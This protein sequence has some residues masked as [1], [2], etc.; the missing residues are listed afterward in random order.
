M[1]IDRQHLNRQH[2]K[3]WQEEPFD[4]RFKS[5]E[6]QH[7]SNCGNEF[8][9]NYCPHCS[10][11]AGVGRIGWKS[12]HQ[13]I[14]DIWGLG[15]RSLLYTLLQLLL[16][17]GQL[18]NDYISGKRQVSFPPV[19]MLFI[20]AVIYSGIAY[21]F[22]PDVLGIQLMEVEYSQLED[23]MERHYS[24]YSLLMSV[25]AILP[26]WIMFRN[27]PRNTRHTLPEGF[28]IQV[29]LSVLAIA[30]GLIFLPLALI[31]PMAL[32]LLL[33]LIEMIYYIIAYKELFGYSLWGT[34]W[35]QA[36]VYLAVIVFA[37]M[38]MLVSSPDLA[39]LLLEKTRLT[40]VQ[41]RLFFI[42]V[43]LALAI[44]IMATGWLVNRIAT[45]W[46]RDDHHGQAHL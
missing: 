2:F 18:I 23:W 27:A 39:S 38:S 43:P 33:L 32:S 45:R 11:R 30:L 24:W 12:V 13:S 37:S 8:K 14:M 16:R 28:F 5:S 1:R 34:V 35:R 40:I 6:C 17:P 44:S 4:Y 3:Q 7:C 41:I 22:L 42:G 46:T 9:G 20:M 25:A 26:T 21:W 31:N 36:F 19:K 29:F 10:Q 15:T